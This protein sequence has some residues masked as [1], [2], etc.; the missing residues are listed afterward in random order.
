M[1]SAAAGIERDRLTVSSLAERLADRRDVYLEDVDNGIDEQ[2]LLHLYN[3]ISERAGHLLLTAR[4]PPVLWK[5][6]LADLRSRL[7]A[8]PAVS[9]AAPDEALISGLLVKLFAYR[10]L[11]VGADLIAYLVPRMER[12]FDA[13]RRLVDALD[14]TALASQRRITVP[15]ARSVLGRLEGCGE[16]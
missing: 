14:K 12:S 4:R 8:A 9:V 5:L 7:L 15:L 13:A 1:Q 2:A 16:I 6:R 10:Q 3:L 11:R